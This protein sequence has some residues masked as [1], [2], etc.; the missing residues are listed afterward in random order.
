[1]TSTASARS[2]DDTRRRLLEAGLELFSAHGYDGVTTR[3]L[4]AHGQVNQSAIPYH[5][6]GKEGVYLA[7]ADSICSALHAR[8]MP[9]LAQADASD[10][11]AQALPDLLAGL[12]RLGQ[13]DPINRQRFA[14][15]MFEQQHPGRAFEQFDTRLFSP[16]IDTLTRLIRALEDSDQDPID[17]R[18]QA[19]VALGLTSTFVSGRAS[20]ESRF[21]TDGRLTEATVQRIEDAIRRLA[22]DLVTGMTARCART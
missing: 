17:A 2:S 16:I 18:V 8:L 22:N 7:V 13:A 21:G 20:I 11:P 4:A 9:L 12:F 15:M 6:G 5:F 19:H 10:S 14:I 1:M 3:A